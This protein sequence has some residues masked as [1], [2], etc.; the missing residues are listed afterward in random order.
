MGSKRT[1]PPLCIFLYFTVFPIYYLYSLKTTLY[2]IKNCWK[3][4]LTKRALFFPLDF[5]L[6]S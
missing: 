6:P 5:K 4:S 1:N 2:W 3:P